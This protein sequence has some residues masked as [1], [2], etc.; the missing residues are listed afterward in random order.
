MI[1]RQN[2]DFSQSLSNDIRFY[3]T[4]TQQVEAN[5]GSL[6]GDIFIAAI[7]FSTHAIHALPLMVDPTSLTHAGSTRQRP[8]GTIS[9]PTLMMLADTGAWMAVLSRVGPLLLSGVRD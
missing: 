3:H 5:L 7:V 8:G 2:R 6:I 1:A 4:H 9:G